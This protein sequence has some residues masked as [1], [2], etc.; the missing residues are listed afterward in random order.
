MQATLRCGSRQ[1]CMAKQ[2]RPSPWQ[3]ALSSAGSELQR[4]RGILG[5]PATSRSLREAG[6]DAG[7]PRP[8]ALVQSNLSETALAPLPPVLRARVLASACAPCYEHD[9]IIPLSHAS[10]STLACG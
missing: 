3:C 2:L 7:G 6:K 5:P 9:S 8:C 1:H 10:A 4:C